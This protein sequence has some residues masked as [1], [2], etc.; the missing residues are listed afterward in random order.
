MNFQIRPVGLQQNGRR[1]RHFIANP[2]GG[3]VFVWR[4]FSKTT[5]MYDFYFFSFNRKG[6]I[7][8]HSKKPKKTGKN[9]AKPIYSK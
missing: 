8:S 6:G 9:L 4:E 1:W 2:R 3:N 5:K 7:F